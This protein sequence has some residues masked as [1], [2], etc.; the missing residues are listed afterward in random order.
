MRQKV[1]NV[2]RMQNTIR[3][4]EKIWHEWQE[5]VEGALATVD[6]SSSESEGSSSEEEGRE[7]Q[8]RT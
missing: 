8:F 1:D 6:E 4:S 5:R 2:V 3:Y 7:T